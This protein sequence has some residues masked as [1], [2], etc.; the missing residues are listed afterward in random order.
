[1]TVSEH[2]HKNEVTDGSILHYGAYY[3]KKH[4]HERNHGHFFD[5]I[6]DTQFCFYT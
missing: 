3:A 6:H 1:M 5:C 2:S 4:T